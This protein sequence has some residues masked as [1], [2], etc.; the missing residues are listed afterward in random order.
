MLE[1]EAQVELDE[2]EQKELEKELAQKYGRRQ[3]GTNADRYV[4]P[5][6]ELDSEGKFISGFAWL[7]RHSEM[8]TV[9]TCRRGDRR[10]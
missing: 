9:M 5:E 2:E 4:E 8:L 7:R 1:G 6:A 10:A 3:L